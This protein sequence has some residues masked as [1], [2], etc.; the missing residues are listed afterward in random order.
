MA[1][2]N[3]YHHG[4]L[5]QALLE[6]GAE[7][8][9]RNGISGVSLRAVA[10]QTGV[11]H[12]APY[13]HFKDKNAMLCGI[14]ATGFNT[15]GQRM[16]QAMEDNPGNP[17]KQ[18]VAAGVA[19]VDLAINNPQLHNLMFGGVLQN[20]DIDMPLQDSSSMSFQGVVDII[21][22]GQMQGVFREG[23][24]NEMALTAWSV[25][26]GFGML[27]T[28]GGLDHIAE[29]K[30]DKLQ[31]ASRVADNLVQGLAYEV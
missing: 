22:K 18:L 19:Y 31:L 16:I 6:A 24:V 26:H 25:V 8:I 17:R 15:L 1:T 20:E 29:K 13:R 23:D 12:T 28:T 3:A 21:S 2:N 14:A 7:L 4:N 11:S 9:E 30:Q 5:R 27:A 10:K